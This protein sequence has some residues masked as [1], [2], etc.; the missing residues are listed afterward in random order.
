MLNNSRVS[1]DTITS[2][3]EQIV[4]TLLLLWKQ[5][6]KPSHLT[7][8]VVISNASGC[9]LGIPVIQEIWC[10]R[11]LKFSRSQHL[12]KASWCTQITSPHTTVQSNFCRMWTEPVLDL[13]NFSDQRFHIHL[14]AFTH[15]KLLTE[16]FPKSWIQLLRISYPTSSWSREKVSSRYMTLIHA[17]IAVT[18]ENICNGYIVNVKKTLSAPTH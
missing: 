3:F 6:F 8:E 15:K 9:L 12:V 14:N 1:T 18:H 7:E 16:P 4:R 17:L 5:T 2:S 13:I 11:Y 10:Q